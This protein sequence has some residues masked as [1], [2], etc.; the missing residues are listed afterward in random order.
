MKQTLLKYRRPFIILASITILQF[1]FGFD[2]KFCLINII[3]L[4]V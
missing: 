3:W 4:L 1:F 2:I